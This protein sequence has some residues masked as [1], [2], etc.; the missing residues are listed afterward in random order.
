[1]VRTVTLVGD[2]PTREREAW[3]FNKEKHVHHHPLP[4]VDASNDVT[5]LAESHH[6]CCIFENQEE[7]AQMLRSFF[8]GGILTNEKILYLIESADLID[9]SLGL[10]KDETFIES[11]EEE[12]GN[13]VFF[14][15]N[16]YDFYNR[17]QIVFLLHSESYTLDNCF[18]AERSVNFLMQF[19][20]TA[21][22]E[23]YAGSRITGNLTTAASSFLLSTTTNQKQ[24]RKSNANHFYLSFHLGSPTFAHVPDQPGTIDQLIE[25]EA[26]L[27]YFFTQQSDCHAWCQYHK[28]Y[29]PHQ[30]LLSILTTHPTAVVGTDV[31]EN[32][33]VSFLIF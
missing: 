22:K 27:N 29:F 14:K 20:E 16:I 12:E 33:Y 8:L 10:L 19:R 4:Q 3:V 17:G 6:I 26:K 23:G 1:M 24:K 11:Y 2:N 18:D 9:Y 25:Y 32:F 31:Y 15:R 7:V 13:Q 21:L 28:S 30:T 5:K